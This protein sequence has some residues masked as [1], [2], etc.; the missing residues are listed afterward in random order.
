[1]TSPPLR[2]PECLPD[3]QIDRVLDELDMAIAEER[4]QPAGVAAP[5]GDVEREILPV[6]GRLVAVRQAAAAVISLIV[7]RAAVVVHAVAGG[8]VDAT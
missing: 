5:G 8:P 4:V 7:R 1:M 6:R 2:V 3:G